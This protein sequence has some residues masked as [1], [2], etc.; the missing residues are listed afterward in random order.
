MC[1]RSMCCYHKLISPF[2]L[3]SVFASFVGIVSFIF[4][5]VLLSFFF[6]SRRRHTR[7]A[8]VTGVQTCALPISPDDYFVEEVKQALL[9][10]PRLGETAT[11]RYDAVFRGG[12]QI[13]TTLDP[14]VQAA[15]LVARDQ[16][17][18]PFALEGQPAL[19]LAG[20]HTAGPRIGQD[21][22]GT[23][24]SASVEPGTG[25]VRAMVGGP[26]FGDE[27]KFNLATQ[28]YRQDRSSFKTF[29]L[30]ELPDQG[31][32]PHDTLPG[33]GPCALTIPSNPGP[34]EVQYPA[35][36]RAPQRP[37]NSLTHNAQPFIPT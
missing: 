36:T 22:I 34:S 29:L 26:G 9:A 20:Q 27:Y 28:G 23:V 7:C 31:P 30:P 2:C 21:A 37:I 10:D 6:S 13:H 3:F 5:Y 15:S 16:T 1:L 12:L 8:L 4:Y 14:A 32:S 18:A 11:E 33:R 17:V 19:F 35:H 25:A 24:A